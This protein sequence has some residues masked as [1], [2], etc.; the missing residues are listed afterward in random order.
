MASLIN[1]QEQVNLFRNKAYQTKKNLFS[2]LETFKIIEGEHPLA[3][4]DYI[5]D[6]FLL[7]EKNINNQNEYT[8]WIDGGLSW[9]YWYKKNLKQANDEEIVSMSIC[10]L[11]FHYIFN[12][13]LSWNNKTKELYFLTIEL[14]KLLKTK[15]IDSEIVITNFSYTPNSVPE[16]DFKYSLS[17]SKEPFFNIKLILKS[18]I[19]S[20]G[21]KAPKGKIDRNLLKL[22]REAFKKYRAEEIK[23]REIENFKD[24]ISNFNISDLPSLHDKIIVEYQL[25]YFSPNENKNKQKKP[26]D[27]T[28]FKDYYIDEYESFVEYSSF[29]SPLF[30]R[31]LLNRLNLIGM[32]TY[33]Y[34]NTARAEIESG[35]NIEKIRQTLFFDKMLDLYDYKPKLMISG[36]F[37]TIMKYYEEVFSNFRSY[38]MFFSEKLENLMLEY[39]LHNYAKF[40]DLTDKYFMSIFRPAVNSFI[41]EI[42]S[43]LMAAHGV[44][45]FIAGGD[46]M[47]RYNYDISFT[48]DIDTKL[49][50]KNASGIGGPDD[51]KASIINIVIENMVK[52][53]NFLDDNKETLF[54]E[55]ISSKNQGIEVFRFAFGEREIRINILVEPQK[56][57]N[58]QQFRS[59]EIKKNEAMPVDLYSLDYRY[60]I[61]LYDIKNRTNPVLLKEYY[62][63]IALLDIVLGEDK[64]F[65]PN[66]FIEVNGIAFASREFILKDFYTT[67]TTEEMALGRISN[68]KVTKD[69]IRYNDIKTDNREI[70]KTKI[71]ELLKEISTIDLTAVYTRNNIL[72]SLINKIL[73]M[74][75]INIYDFI[76]IN[77]LTNDD[78]KL[79]AN[80]PKLIELFTDIKEFKI[81]LPF[82]DLNGLDINYDTYLSANSPNEISKIYLEIF[83]L[84]C[85][86][87]VNKD[88]S[89][90]HAMPYFNNLIKLEYKKLLPS[91]SSGVNSKS[92]QQTS[93][94]ISS[95]SKAIF[96]APKPPP[97]PKPPKPLPPSYSQPDVV[98][99]RSSLRSSA[100]KN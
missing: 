79:I 38:N 33:S 98:G 12:E 91:Y 100:T 90:K 63:Q 18:D 29:L 60:K 83:K 50:F 55:F 57:N 86:P 24:G 11:K 1:I 7:L 43:Q 74:E 16:F 56:R 28:L 30:A 44:K 36:T 69:I 58:F 94:K 20:G 93:T 77:N 72:A 52:L 27:I 81:N 15:G 26:L 21:A 39:N 10:N 13:I 95:K 46:S 32:L 41:R 5:T 34:L 47:R 45:L 67:Y 31:K 64:D 92:I 75:R 54:H 73:L 78:Y 17:P 85:N 2:F 76:I 87:N 62:R 53:R 66:D 68:G 22:K 49:H 37:D 71:D 65:N 19:K 84:M 14:Q 6:K 35:I 82:E 80:Y 88:K 99:R 96:K 42:N 48:A 4:N 61:T 9:Y 25:E 3:I 51:I 59:R 23:E 40:I 8:Y 70:Y 97:S 89:V